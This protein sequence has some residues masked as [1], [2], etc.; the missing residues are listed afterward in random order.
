MRTPEHYVEHLGMQAHPEGGWYK[1]TYRSKDAI[2][3]SVL[4]E[5]GGD[6][7]FST[8]IYFLLTKENFSA[9][10]RIK[11]DEMWHFYDGDGLTV[12]EIRANGDYIEHKLGLDLEKGEQPQLVIVANSWFASEVKKGGNWCLVGC[13]VSPGFDFKDFELAERESLIQQ[14]PDHVE[15]IT[16]LTRT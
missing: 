12:H 6:R 8:G 2:P 1:E 10:H 3:S 13:T 11:S 14:Y 7:S 9:F 16:Q 5:F 4:D 15:R